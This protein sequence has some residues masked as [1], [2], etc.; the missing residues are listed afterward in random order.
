MGSNENLVLVVSVFLGLLLVT[1]IMS[2]INKGVRRVFKKT[3]I[4]VMFQS[5]CKKVLK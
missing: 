4:A 2:S 1:L 5:F 3:A